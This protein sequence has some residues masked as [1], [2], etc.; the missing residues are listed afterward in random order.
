MLTHGI[1]DRKPSLQGLQEL[2]VGQSLLEQ[3]L[4]NVAAVFIQVDEKGTP[5][6][7]R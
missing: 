7:W 5:S 1:V 2:F 6:K 3:A 4:Y